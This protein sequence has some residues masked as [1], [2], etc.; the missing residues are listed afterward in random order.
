MVDGLL[1]DEAGVYFGHCDHPVNLLGKSLLKQYLSELKQMVYNKECNNKR[2]KVVRNNEGNH[3]VAQ[4]VV[5]EGDRVL[6]FC[7]NMFVSKSEEDLAKIVELSKL[8]K[9]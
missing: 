7:S 6:K 4:C 8:A 1:A 5:G 3:V 2:I 9:A